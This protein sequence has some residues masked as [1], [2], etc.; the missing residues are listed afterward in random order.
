M[1][2]VA[3]G[4]A[5]V[6][7]RRHEAP[8]SLDFYPTPPW[9]TRALCKVVLG[10]DDGLSCWEPAA[11]EGHMAEVLREFFP[12]V[13]ASDVH[14]YGKGYAIGSFTGEGP[15]VAAC[16]FQPHWIISNPPFNLGE[17][18][19]LRA[20]AQARSGVAMLLRTVWV[21]GGERYQ[22]IFSKTPPSMIAVFCE[23]VPMQKGSWNPDG[24]SATSYAWFIWRKPVATTTQFVWIPPGQ[25]QALERPD[26]RR[27]YAHPV[28]IDCP[29]FAS[30]ETAA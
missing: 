13:H 11:G 17:E 29:L 7:A 8:D 30:L 22:G 28:S 9:A 3:S 1:K 21:E 27:R 5:S 6:M 18:F 20:L 12:I 14:D 25:R 10:F 24:S 16:P 2:P 23:R 4:H 15:D 19:V 26:D